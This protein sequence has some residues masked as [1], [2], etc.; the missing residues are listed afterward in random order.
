MLEIR[1]SVHFGHDLEVYETSRG[2][3]KEVIRM[4]SRVCGRSWAEDSALEVISL[5]MV[6]A[7]LV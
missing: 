4:E 1:R 7:E 6:L 5:Q 3:V 2:N